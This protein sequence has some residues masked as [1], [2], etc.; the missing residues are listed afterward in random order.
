MSRKSTYNLTLGEQNDFMLGRK[1]LFIQTPQWVF[2]VGKG[3]VPWAV[4]EVGGD[5]RRNHLLCLKKKL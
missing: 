2:L 5:H 4:L 1:V 3:E